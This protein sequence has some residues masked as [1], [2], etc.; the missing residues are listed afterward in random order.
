[1]GFTIKTAAS[2]K[3]KDVRLSVP[4]SM[5]DL[6]Q[7]MADQAGVDLQEA[8]RQGLAYA[9]KASSRSN[10]KESKDAPKSK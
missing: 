6:Y 9:L 4:V 1:M 10:K 5:A 8:M 3:M 2:E 7:S